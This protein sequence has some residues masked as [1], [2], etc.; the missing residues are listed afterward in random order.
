MSARVYFMKM[1]NGCKDV[2]IMYPQDEPVKTD[3]LL[4]L[5]TAG[6]VRWP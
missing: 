2:L 4:C 3:C 5:Y 1:V 6:E